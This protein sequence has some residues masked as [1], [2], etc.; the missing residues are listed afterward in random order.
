MT[1]AEY[2]VQTFA[3]LFRPYEK[4]FG[5]TSLRFEIRCR[6][7][8]GRESKGVPPREWFPLTPEGYAQAALLVTTEGRFYD[9]YVG[10]LPRLGNV[11]TSDLVPVAATLW[12]SVDNYEAG[13]DGAFQRIKAA[14]F[15][16]IEPLPPPHLALFSGGGVHACWFLSELRD[17]V[18]PEAKQQFNATVN[19]LA[20]CIGG[21]A[22]GATAETNT[23]YLSYMIRVPGSY[24][25]KAAYGDERKVQLR[26]LEPDAE[27]KPLTWWRAHLPP[28]PLSE[29][30][31]RAAEN[32]RKYGDKYGGK[33]YG[34]ERIGEMPQKALALINTPAPASKRHDTAVEIAAILFAAG[35]GKQSATI[36]LESFAARNN[37]RTE[38]NE[39]DFIVRHFE[40][41]HPN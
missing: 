5:V 27:A 23:G 4:L 11:G 12:A 16:A 14:R 28:E 37:W 30:E 2:A 6:H 24:N 10:V 31:K 26:R 9:C 13:P 3:A 19:R 36:V 25:R 7:P 18:E 17:L 41:K 39:I 40:K 1:A 32:R 33:E 35:W 34:R 20:L 8:K 21:S 29:R 15:S 22:P 38:K